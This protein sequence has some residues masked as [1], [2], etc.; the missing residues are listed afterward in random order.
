[1]YEF[2]ALLLVF[3][4]MVASVVLPFLVFTLIYYIICICF[5]LVFSWWYALGIFLVCLVIRWVISA[6]RGNNG[7]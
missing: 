2:F 7:K 3:L 4:V 6:S 5:G 1:M